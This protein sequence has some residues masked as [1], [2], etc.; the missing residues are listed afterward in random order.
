MTAAAMALD[1]LFAD[2]NVARDAVY[3]PEGGTPVLVRVVTRRADETTGFGEARIWSETTRMDLRVSEVPNPRPGDRIEIDG[4][5]FL[6]QAE[7][8][9]DR[10]RLVWTVD[11]RPA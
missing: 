10:E 6:I 8:V 7:P 4:E 9:R 1:V 3:A 2:V 5:A 11:L